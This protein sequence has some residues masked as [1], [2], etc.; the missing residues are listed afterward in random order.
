MAQ[1]IGACLESEDQRMDPQY[2]QKSLAD[3]RSAENDQGRHLEL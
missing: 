3:S 1:R 2:A